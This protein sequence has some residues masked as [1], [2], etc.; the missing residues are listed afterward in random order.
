MLANVSAEHNSRMV[1]GLAL[2]GKM[3]Y[4][5]CKS[6]SACHKQRQRAFDS[7]ILGILFA[8]LQCLQAG[9][10][11]GRGTYA[12]SWNNQWYRGQFTW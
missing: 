2:N 4:T 7:E 8:V 10:R 1:R 11:K 12:N 5:F 6:G 9:R 3:P